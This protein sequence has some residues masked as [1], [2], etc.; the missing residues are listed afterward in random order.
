MQNNHTKHFPLFFPMM[1]G[2]EQLF[3]DFESN[4]QSTIQKPKGFPQFDMYIE[5]ISDENNKTE[6]NVIVIEM[7]VAG[8][9][10][11][12][13][14]FE[15]ANK[16]VSETPRTILAISGNKSQDFKDEKAE[17]ENKVQYRVKSLS[18]K[19]F[20][21]EFIIFDNIEKIEPKLENGILTIKIYEKRTEHNP[22]Q[23]EW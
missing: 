14:S 20:K 22:I 7:G 21:K 2:L 17:L 18:F 5:K 12:D 6:Q 8:F 19:S 13:I 15:T 4:I 16:V 3:E 10:K 23:I 9:A 1:Q 11:E